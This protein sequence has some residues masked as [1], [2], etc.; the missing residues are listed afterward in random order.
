MRSGHRDAPRSRFDLAAAAPAGAAR[1]PRP[2]GGRGRLALRRDDLPGKT[3]ISSANWRGIEL[4]W[5]MERWVEGLQEGWGSLGD[6]LW[7]V[8]EWESEE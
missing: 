1:G 2:A 4:R 7:G 6:D 3:G 8:G 5:E